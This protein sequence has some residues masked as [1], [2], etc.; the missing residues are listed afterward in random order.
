MVNALNGF[1]FRQS[2]SDYSLFTLLRWKVQIN[3]LLYV[4]DLIVSRNDHVAIQIF[5]EYLSN[6]FHMKELGVLKYFLGIEVARN[7]EGIH[8]CQHKYALNIIFEVS[9][10]GAKPTTFPL[11]QNHILALV[12][13]VLLSNPE[14]Y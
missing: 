3:V 1:G 14:K 12:E 4:D 10:L 6:C 5:K 13:G 7:Y 11:E 8:I 9:L 2:Y